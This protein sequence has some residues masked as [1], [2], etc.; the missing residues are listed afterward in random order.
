M[1]WF[2]IA[3]QIASPL[4]NIF[5]ID[6][7]L[8]KSKK[9]VYHFDLDQ[10]SNLAKYSL[11]IITSV[12]SFVSTNNHS[13]TKNDKKEYTPNT[14]NTGYEPPNHSTIKGKA[15]EIKLA[16]TNISNEPLATCFGST[17]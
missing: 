2:N 17:I 16:N 9:L 3:L 12:L 11:W 7:K 8:L 13:F 15:K 14:R 1:Q 6:I 10:A 4:I 5:R